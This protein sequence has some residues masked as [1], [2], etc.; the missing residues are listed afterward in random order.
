MDQAQHDYA[1]S[2]ARWAGLA[3]LGAADP[4][5]K[6]SLNF[7]ARASEFGNTVSS[8]SKVWFDDVTVSPVPEPAAAWLFSVGLLVVGLKKLSKR[9]QSV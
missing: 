6:M 7:F 4:I 1:A 9:D 3:G 2:F 5:N 8:S